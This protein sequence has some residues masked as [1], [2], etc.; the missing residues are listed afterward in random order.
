MTGNSVQTEPVPAFTVMGVRIAAIDMPSLVR[1]VTTAAETKNGY[2][3]AANV[4]NTVLAFENSE[5]RDI[6]NGSLLTFPD[7]GPLASRGR[8]RGF[9]QTRRTAGPDLMNEILTISPARGWRHFFYGS[10]P[11]T[12]DK[13]RKNIEGSLPDIQIAGMISP[14][15]RELTPEEDEAFVRR[16]N[17]AEPDFI[18]A[19]LGAPKQ[20]RWM[21]EH[22]GKVRGLMLGVGA[23]FD[24]L[25]GNVK[26]APLWMRMNN[27]EW[28]YR[29]AQEPRRL[30]G[31]YFRT[32]LK[33]I[34]EAVI[35][36]K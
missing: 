8:K 14:P 11:E 28:A 5:Y 20:E 6:L 16:I 23:A 31:R 4:H 35:R 32:N 17:A 13:M 22:Q 19:G 29:L 27:L 18:W 12:L 21:A 36:G 10:T 2:L 25:A 3:C 34:L 7:G 30:F 24:F 33:F 9:P 26:R 15:F 1:F